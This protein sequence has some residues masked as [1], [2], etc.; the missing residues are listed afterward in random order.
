M[1]HPCTFSSLSRLDPFTFKMFFPSGKGIQILGDCLSKDRSLEF[2]K[3]KIMPFSPDSRT[4]VLPDQVQ[5]A[6]CTGPSSTQQSP[7]PSR[8]WG[9]RATCLRLCWA[10]QWDAVLRKGFFCLFVFCVFVCCFCLKATQTNITRLQVMTIFLAHQ[11]PDPTFITRTT[12]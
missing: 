4:K 5:I 12:P 10:T 1:G 3:Q 9:R 11:T 6:C 2:K 8:G 7:E